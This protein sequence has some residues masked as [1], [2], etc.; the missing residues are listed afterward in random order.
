VAPTAADERSPH[1]AL[2]R[3]RAVAQTG[4]QGIGFAQDDLREVRDTIGFAALQQEIE[5]AGL[6]HVEVEVLNNWWETGE[7]RRHS[8][9]IRELLFDAAATLNAR[10]IKIATAIG[11][12]LDSICSLIEPLADLAD[13]AAARDLRLAIE[14]MPF[15]MLHTVPQAAELLRAVNRPNCGLLVD[16]WHVFRAGTT[17]ADLYACVTSNILFAVELADAAQPVGGDLF[18]DTIMNRRFCGEGSFDLPGLIQT[19]VKVGY[20]GPW[21]VEIISNYH[22]G[23]RLDVALTCAQRTARAALTGALG[24]PVATT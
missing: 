21:G 24:E 17:L 13:Q 14:P 8:D 9:E 19:L 20:T 1:D 15:S 22:R 18:Y 12:P 16:A 3:V 4:W 5:D 23:L 7:R 6:R 2:D 10:H 11:D